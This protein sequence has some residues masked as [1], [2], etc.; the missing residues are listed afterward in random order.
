MGAGKGG[1]RQDES[2]GDARH[3]DDGERNDEIRETQDAGTTEHAVRPSKLLG[4][5]ASARRRGVAEATEETAEG[6]GRE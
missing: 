2:R 3:G 1:G 5:E 6:G 4:A